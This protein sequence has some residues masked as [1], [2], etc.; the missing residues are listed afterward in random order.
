MSPRVHTPIK[1]PL[2]QDTEPSPSSGPPRAAMLREVTLCQRWSS[3]KHGTNSVRSV[4]RTVSALSGPVLETRIPGPHSRPTASETPGRGP[5]LWAP[6]RPRQLTHDSHGAKSFACINSPKTHSILGGGNRCRPC[7]TEDKTGHENFVT[8][9][10]S[11]S[12]T[13][14]RLAPPFQEAVESVCLGG[15]PAWIPDSTLGVLQRARRR[16]LDPG[17]DPGVA[18]L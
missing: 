4:V 8:R 15:C 10:R 2:P 1:L 16:A 7:F 18:T 17:C 13:R 3:P 6:L 14:A 5:A 11:K 9:M 12:Q